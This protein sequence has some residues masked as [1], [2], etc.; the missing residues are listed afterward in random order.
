MNPEFIRS[1]DLATY[2][3][4]GVVC[5]R[6]AFPPDWVDFLRGAVDVAMADP[7]PYAE[8]YAKP[9]GGR[10]FGD[11]E[12]AGRHEAFM[13]FAM[14]SPAAEIAGHVM[15][16]RKINFFYDQLLVKEPGA[17]ARTP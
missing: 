6:Q 5:L 1:G 16:S 3:R 12:L 13:R 8:E 2:D 7:G 15:Q 11:L 4:D 10:F 17:N 9:G 14:E